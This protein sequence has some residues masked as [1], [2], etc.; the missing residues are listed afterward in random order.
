MTCVLHRARFRPGLSEREAAKTII[1]VVEYSCLNFRSAS[2]VY[3]EYDSVFNGIIEQRRMISFKM[4]NRIFTTT[5]RQ[6]SY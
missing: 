3:F 4:F 2:C 6:I 5:R 1:E